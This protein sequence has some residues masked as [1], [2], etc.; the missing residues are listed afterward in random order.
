M[1]TE[2]VQSARLAMEYAEKTEENLV[3]VVARAIL[4]A[5]LHTEYKKKLAAMVA[6]QESKSLAGNE[7]TEQCVMLWSAFVVAQT[8]LCRAM[9]KI[10]GL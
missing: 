9:R 4:A 10:Q 5:G 3:E 1:R 7:L 8:N 2:Q 6:A